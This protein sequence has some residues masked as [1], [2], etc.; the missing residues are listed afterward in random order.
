MSASFAIRPMKVGGEVVGLDV[1][2]PFDDATQR[3]LYAAWLEHGILLFRDIDTKAK[4][5]AIS[6]C[7]GELEVH[8]MPELWADGERL[9]IELGG[10]HTAPAFVY[11]DKDIRIGRIPWHRDTAYT[12]DICK[13][14]MLRMV[15]IP[16]AGGETLFS[17]CARAYDALPPRLKAKVETLEYKGTLR[18]SPEDQC[19][20]GALWKTARRATQDEYP[21]PPRLNNLNKA[22]ETR[23]PSVVHPV[24]VR[25]PES[26][27]KC[28]FLSPTY[29]DCFLGLSQ[30]EG[31]ELLAELVD[32]M[33]GPDYTF[34]FEWSQNDAIVWDNRRVMHAAMGIGP[35]ERRTGLRTTLAGALRTGRYF[36][37]NAS[38]EGLRPILD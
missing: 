22:T 6:R 15:E 29:V 33:T 24:V 9:L 8:P 5:L 3:A 21:M 20:P 17:D 1:G 13:G 35:G 34:A 11:D 37:A 23:Y 19:K 28:L 12:P 38:T 26:G 30:A 27:R 14:A 36:D 2:A 16:T 18:M 10:S 32:H 7:F 25:H 31:D 4:H